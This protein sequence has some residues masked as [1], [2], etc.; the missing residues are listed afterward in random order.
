MNKDLK[1]KYIKA[2]NSIYDNDYTYYQFILDALEAKEKLN[3]ICKRHG[4]I[5]FDL[6]RNSKDYKEYQEGYTDLY[7]NI[8]DSDMLTE[9]EFKVL[10]ELI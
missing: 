2:L 8:D 6:V 4:Q 1:A 9:D 10:K 5:D 7:Y 3:D